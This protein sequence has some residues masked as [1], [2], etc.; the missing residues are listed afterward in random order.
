MERLQL[1]SSHLIPNK[2]SQETEDI[3]AHVPLAPPDPIL[4]TALAF[5]ADTSKD[6]VNLGIGAYRDD[7]DKPYVFNVVKKA[8]QEILNDS[9]L[10]KEYLPID[11]HPDFNRLTANLLFGDNNPSLKNRF[12][13]SSQVVG[14]TG[15]LRVGFEFV[16]FHLPGPVYVSKPTWVNHIQI[17]QNLGL[18][19]REYSY[20]DG[21]TRGLDFKGLCSDLKQAPPGAIILLHACA[22]NPTGVDPS[23]EQ[24]RELAQ[25]FKARRLVPFF[26]SAY[27][28]FASGDLEKD[29]LSIRIFAEAGLQMIIAQSF[30]K[31]FGLYGERVGAIH[32]LC[33][34]K[35]TAD[36]VSSQIKILIRTIYSNPPLH[37]AR[38]VAKILGSK[39]TFEEWRTELAQVAGRILGMRKALRD[40]LERL[41]TKGT[42][43]HITN[44]IG[45]FSYTGLTPNQCDVLIKKHHIYLIRNG[46][47]SMAGVT[48]KN[49]AYL[50]KAIKDAVETANQTVYF[51]T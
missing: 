7:N 23:P 31:N 46:R 11:G 40:E 24:W 17:C 44:Q 50:A 22:H 21:K 12:V 16:K 34:S 51:P 47:I 18:V 4:G 1:V 20:Y 29:A 36:S 49:V 5:K 38:I 14:G 39:Q 27:Q 10:D 28:G 3:F 30:S 6:K 48:T 8:E 35:S 26:D 43:E 41:G 13:V 33:N 9:K 2:V 19:Y 15:S 42:W 25:I 37:G 45:M 32:V